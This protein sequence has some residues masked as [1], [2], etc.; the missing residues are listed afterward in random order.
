LSNVTVTYDTAILTVHLRDGKHL[1]VS[2]HAD[3][4]WSRRAARRIATFLNVPGPGDDD[5]PDPTPKSDDPTR[6][7]KCGFGVK[8][9]GARCRQC[10]FRTG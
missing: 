1:V 6:C 4:D 2:N 3:L 10:G 7:P 5:P 8:C 9:D